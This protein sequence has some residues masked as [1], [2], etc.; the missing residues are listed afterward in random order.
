MAKNSLK[1]IEEDEKKVIN[2]LLKN[3]N[4][5]INEIAKICGFSRQKVW[6]IIKNL[7]N[8][9]TIWGYTTVVNEE[10]QNLKSYMLLVKRNNKPVE[11]D[12]VDSI[13]NRDLEKTS[14]KIGV[15]IDSS[16]YVYGPYDWIVC[17]TAE[18]IKTAKKFCEIFISQ[19]E[20]Y[21]SETHMMEK[22]F[23]AKK[24]GIKNPDIE[25]LRDFFAKA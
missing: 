11:K 20:G 23:A 16:Y 3:A 25:Q 24:C 22:M 4:K 18:N 19:F 6:R 5:S 1:Q 15:N 21:L 7:E 17:F 2:E 14:E 12:V 9:N 8:N 10:K 13:I